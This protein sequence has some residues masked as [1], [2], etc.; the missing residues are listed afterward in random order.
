QINE[1]KFTPVISV[2]TGDSSWLLRLRTYKGQ[3]VMHLM[4]T[5][6]TAIP[7]PYLKESGEPVLKDFASSSKAG[8]V[9]YRIRLNKLPSNLT[10]RSPELGSQQKPVLLT[11]NKD[12]VILETDLSNLILYAVIQ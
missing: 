11:K 5:G 8:V 6:L 2:V 7:H 10:L 1:K 3:W 9:K 12:E 4:N